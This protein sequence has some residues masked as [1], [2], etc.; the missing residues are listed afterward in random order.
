MIEFFIKNPAY[1]HSLGA[2]LAFLIAYLTHRSYKKRGVLTLSYFRNAFIFWGLCNFTRFI[3][4]LVTDKIISN[5]LVLSR[6]TFL[7]IAFIY[8]SLTFSI[9]IGRKKKLILTT[10]VFFAVLT[11]F[12]AGLFVFT[13]LP[14]I[15][16][17]IFGIK[18]PEVMRLIYYSTI[19]GTAG[20]YF[21]LK[22]F[23]S[24]PGRLRSFILGIGLM[25]FI[26]GE[27]FHV[28]PFTTGAIKHFVAD[29][30]I[31][32]SFVVMLLGVLYKSR[33]SDAGTGITPR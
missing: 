14:I 21:L 28:N 25:L 18:L 7:A 2:P 12:V 33:S 22:A 17:K 1:I 27:Y 9:I 15:K 23:S 20:I 11:V 26:F 24:T 8:L 30:A 19:L 16:N 6:H 5:W 10:A 32:T 31:V 13:D 29:S 4:I 3:D